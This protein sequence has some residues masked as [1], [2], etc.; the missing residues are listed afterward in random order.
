MRTPQGSR[1][2]LLTLASGLGF[3]LAPSAQA[4]PRNRPA[5]APAVTKVDVERL[6]KKIEDQQRRLDKLIKL[7]IQYLQLLAAMTDDKSPGVTPE[8]KPPQPKLG[9]PPA[10]PDAPAKPA[11]AAAEPKPKA[12]P[13][14]ALAV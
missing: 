2:A 13:A 12:T 7:Q 3:T 4:Q 8:P 5:P 10:K 14:A 11:V 6:D 9:T 1:L